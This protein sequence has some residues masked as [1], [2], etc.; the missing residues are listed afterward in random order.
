MKRRAQ[1]LSA[2]SSVKRMSSVTAPTITAV[3]PSCFSMY[4]AIF[5]TEIGGLFTLDMYI[6]FK[7]TLQNFESVRRPR[8]A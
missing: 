2:G 6:L 7:T 3:S 5:D 1:T 4:L 8:K